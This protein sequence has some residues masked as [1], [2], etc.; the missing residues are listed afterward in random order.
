MIVGVKIR[1]VDVGWMCAWVMVGLEGCDGKLAILAI[2][3]SVLGMK[4]A[5]TYA[6]TMIHVQTLPSISPVLTT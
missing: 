5:I 2:W 1:V 6:L 4:V 3:F